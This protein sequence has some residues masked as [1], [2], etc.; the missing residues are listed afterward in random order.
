[1]F[2]WWLKEAIEEHVPGPHVMTLSTTE[3]DGRPSS[4]VLICKNVSKDGQWYLAPAADSLKGHQDGH[5]HAP[6]TFHW[7]RIG[8]QVRIRGTVAPAEADAADSLVPPV[9]E[10]EGVVSAV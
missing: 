7:P 10:V 1:M 3:A 4:R 8:R 2:A 9:T 5:P 6:L